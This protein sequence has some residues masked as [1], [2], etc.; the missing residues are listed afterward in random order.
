MIIAI[1]GPAGAGKSTVSRLL[2]ERL[3]CVRIDTG[4]LYRAVALAATQ[5]GFA[6]QDAAA[7]EAFVK[8]LDLRVTQDAVFVNGEDV[9]GAIR[10]PEASRA[11]SDFAAL[12]SVRAGLM[13]LQRRLGRSAPSV[14]DG[15]DIGTVVFP[16]ADAKIYL[17]ASAQ[18]R[19]KRRLAE[20]HA[21]GLG[22]E[23]AEVLAEIEARDAQDMNRAIAP[24]RQAPDAAL[25]DATSLTLE[26]AVD[27][28]YIAVQHQL[29]A[30]RG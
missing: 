24:L 28:C 13:A 25:V 12:P 7:L 22:G 11:A 8:A 10:T 2:A 18:E 4:A 21:R 23:L 3:G 27:A 17:T 14:L 15:R 20:L 30:G 19:A 29:A 26:G 9:S 6:A 5:A 1:D 16:D